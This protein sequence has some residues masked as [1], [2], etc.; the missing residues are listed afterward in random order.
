MVKSASNYNS[1]RKVPDR[2]EQKGF[3]GSKWGMLTVVGKSTKRMST[4]VLY[5]CVCDC[6]GETLATMPWLKRGQKKSCGCQRFVG[7]DKACESNRTH[8]MSTTTTYKTWQS[9]RQRCENPNNDQYENYGGRGIRVCE[10]WS[11]FENF[12]EDMG[13][14]PKN[15]TIDR[16]DSNGDYTPENC[17]WA[18]SKAQSNN[19]RDS[20][21]VKVGEDWVTVIEAAN[22]LGLTE[23]G[24]RHRYRRG[25]MEIRREYED[26]KAQARKNGAR[27]RIC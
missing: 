17:R 25:A 4:Y 20:I 22:I 16:I 5:N 14:R 9:M 10:R 27:G 23:S 11:S 15:H 12:L 3:I 19:R 24:I 6:G 1:T 13:E 2:P 26:S 18:T 7:R 8:G 21:K